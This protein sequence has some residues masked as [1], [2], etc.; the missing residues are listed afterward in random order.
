[1][2]I[3]T[4]IIVCSPFMGAIIGVAGWYL[5]RYSVCLYA[6]LILLLVAVTL[7]APVR[8]E[9]TAPVIVVNDFMCGL[10]RVQVNDFSGLMI[11]GQP[12]GDY[13]TTM[14]DAQNN[15]VHQFGEKAEV[16]VTQ[17]SRVAFRLVGESRWAAC[18][19][20]VFHDGAQ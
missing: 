13:K 17:Y 20:V 6:L 4:W 3:E 14:L 1:M 12:Y 11:D 16:R 9:N 15:Y 18:R 8:A 2:N 10:H 7:S 5:F 19:P